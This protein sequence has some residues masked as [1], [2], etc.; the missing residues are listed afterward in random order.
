MPYPP[1]SF[2]N[3]MDRCT[4]SGHTPLG[5]VMV[6]LVRSAISLVKKGSEQGNDE[7]QSCQW[8]THRLFLLFSLA[9]GRVGMQSNFRIFPSIYYI[10]P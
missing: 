2:Y 8:F 4:H 7:Q 1:G 10:M 3:H 5:P 6:T 9:L